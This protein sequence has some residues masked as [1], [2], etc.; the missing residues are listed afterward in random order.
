MRVF[1]L[2]VFWFYSMIVGILLI[3]SGILL[4]A[5]PELL[6]FFFAGILLFLGICFIS[7]ALFLRGDLIAKGER[8]RFFVI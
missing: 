5:N 1:G 4:I 6:A 8:K 3:L 7:S 2:Q